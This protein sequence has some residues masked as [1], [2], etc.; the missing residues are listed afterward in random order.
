MDTIDE[1]KARIDLAEYAGHHTVLKP[2]GK[3]RLKGLCPLHKESNPSFMIYIES[4][5]WHCFGCNQGGDV[6]DLVQ[7]LEKCDFRTALNQLA[8]QAGVTLPVTDLAAEMQKQKTHCHRSVLEVGI[9]YFEKLMHAANSPGMAYA[10]SR[11]WHTRGEGELAQD[12]IRSARLGY[13]DGN[14]N[15]LQ[16]ALKSAQVD[17]PSPAARALL[18]TPGPSLVYPFLQHRSVV[19]YAV[20][21]ITPPPGKAKAWNPPAELLGTKPL[22]AN[23]LYSP[24]SETVLVVEGQGDAVTLAQWGMPALATVGTACSEGLVEQL[25][26]HRQV[27]I[28]VEKDEAG[29][30]HAH[31]L[32]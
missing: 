19:Y 32:A 23:A 1:V 20:R 27:Y 21:L 8:H 17:L 28:G 9:S 14:R 11:G 16:Q 29:I 18:R 31:E 12:T 26:A 30:K 2:A 5:R 15:G 10:R 25:R 22:Y 3:N 4:Q 24:A 6:L 13:Y 7:Q